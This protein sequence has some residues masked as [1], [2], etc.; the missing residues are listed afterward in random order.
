[1]AQQFLD[2]P[3]IGPMLQQ[4]RCEAVAEHVGRDISFDPGTPDPLLDAEPQGDGGESGAAFGKEYRCRGLGGDE[5]GTTRLK[6]TAQGLDGLFA[7]RDDP[8]LVTLANDRHEGGLKL[9]LLEA[10]G[11]QLCQAQARCI[12]DLEHSLIT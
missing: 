5:M 4:V 9:Q 6:V 1:M 7:Q 10:K 8:L 3:Q 2:D 11:A 12:G